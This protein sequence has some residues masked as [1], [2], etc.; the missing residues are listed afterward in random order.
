MESNENREESDQ[1]PEEQPP[2]QSA[3]DDSTISRSDAVENVGVPNE[4][5][6]ASG[7]PRNAG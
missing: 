6:Q 4:K 5:G 7:N 1:L 2:D 3:E